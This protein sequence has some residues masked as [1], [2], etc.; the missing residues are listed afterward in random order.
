MQ[1]YFSESYHSVFKCRA[2]SS[3][4]CFVY[5]HTSGRHCRGPPEASLHECKDASGGVLCDTLHP[6]SP[7]SARTSIHFPS[8]CVHMIYTL[9]SVLFVLRMPSICTYDTPREGGLSAT[10]AQTSNPCFRQLQE[11]RNKRDEDMSLLASCPPTNW[12]SAVQL[13]GGAKASWS[14][15]EGWTK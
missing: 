12:V 7:P 5:T 14:T 9:M 6:W 2:S 8:E 10:P 1:T 11:G 15:C 4:R 13:R 3:G